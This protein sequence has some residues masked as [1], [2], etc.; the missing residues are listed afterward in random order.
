M[1]AC[2]QGQSLWRQ[3]NNNCMSRRPLQLLSRDIFYERSKT[4]PKNLA[5]LRVTK[6]AGCAGLP[7]PVSGSVRYANPTAILSNGL[8]I[9]DCTHNVE[10][11]AWVMTWI[12]H[13]TV[14]RC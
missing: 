12:T 7:S 14:L 13:H 10:T 11:H 9:A 8:R 6:S 1:V 3:L 2:G 4:H 5:A